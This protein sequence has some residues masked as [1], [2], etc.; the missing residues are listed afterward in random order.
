MTSTSSIV[1]PVILAGGAGT[2]LWPL[3]TA[4]APKHLLPLLGPSTLFDETL[5]RV[6]ND[7]LFADPI[8]VA[9]VA[10]EE[11]LAGLLSGLSN[12]RLLLEPVKRDSGPAIALAA[13]AADDDELLLICPSDQHVANVD[14]FREAVRSGAEAARAGAIVT[15]GIEPDHP[16]TGFGYIQA[17]DGEGAARP[18]AR[19]VEKPP[20]D[21]AEAMIAAG[22]HYWN[23]GIFLAS[24][25]TWRAAF[26]AHAPAMLEA[27]AKALSA[28]VT[29]GIVTRIDE[30]EFSRSP[31][32]SIDYAVME[33]A[34]RVMVV[35]VS[36]G[37]SDVGSWQSVHE[38][39]DKDEAGNSVGNGHT[40]ID[41]RG[42]LVRSTGP[43]VAVVGLEDLA[44]IA[45]KDAVLVIRRSDAQRVR[46]AA[47]WF[48]EEQQS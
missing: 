36:M 21:A 19:F 15:F 16:A 8:V 1:R 32:Q 25:A 38:A 4:Q 12:A 24:A 6:S 7:P 31:A 23:A 27:A 46:E 45:S 17:G 42:N 13:V 39:A 20:L 41:G 22:G 35:P 18:V 30:S 47:A 11:A 9:N 3:S 43:R 48:A 29:D 26:T 44:V 33:K 14:A 5:E 2:R 34:D 37:W 28:G 10:Q 40:V